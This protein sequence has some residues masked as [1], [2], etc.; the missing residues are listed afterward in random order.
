M[1]THTH[2]YQP[3]IISSGV[4]R[5]GVVIL[6]SLKQPLIAEDWETTEEITQGSLDVSST[7]TL[8]LL[9]A[10]EWQ[11]VQKVLIHIHKHTHI[12]HSR[13]HQLCNKGMGTFT[14]S[15]MKTHTS[16]DVHV[17]THTR[18]HTGSMCTNT[19]SHIQADTCYPWKDTQTPPCIHTYSCTYK[20]DGH[21]RHTHRHS[22]A[23]AH[24]T[25]ENPH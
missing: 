7:K 9:S 22:H 4:L 16:T 5:V 17:Y 3:L 20:E 12:M 8:L 24:T 11:L 1:Y 25:H 10:L 18:V 13:S 6:V 23:Q 19:P 14:H 2:T 21:K 15:S